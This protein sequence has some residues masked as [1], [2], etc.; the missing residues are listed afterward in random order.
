MSAFALTAA[1]T[2]LA[3]RWV[4]R[5]NRDMGHQP[6]SSWTVLAPAPLA[7]VSPGPRPTLSVVI[8]YYRGADVIRHAVQSV[9]DQTLQ[10]DEIVICDDGS[11]DDLETALG[12]LRSAVR[13]VRKENAGTPSAMNA[14]AR[15]AEGE[16]LVQLDQDDVFLP[17]RLEAIAAAAVSRP[18]LDLIATDAFIEFDGKPICRFSESISF[19]TEDQRTGILRN[20]FFAWPAVRRS[21]LLAAGG[22]DERRTTG[23]YDWE[24][25]MRL[26]LSGARVG[27]VD[28]PL[29]VWKL[30]R[31]SVSSDPTVNLEALLEALID[32]RSHPG[33]LPVERDELER[34]IAEQVGWIARSKARR[35][36]EE[37][38]PDARRRSLALL[39]GRNFGASTRAKAAL[40]VLSPALARSLGMR[41][42]ERDPAARALGSRLMSGPS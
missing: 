33:L 27:L 11:P 40:G 12:T 24:C 15:T 1:H 42:T 38:L 28:E 22:Y 29:Y 37:N 3:E 25:F 19:Q 41:R 32:L 6:E 20:S 21:T 8:P 39:F 4:S 26:I 17:R 2:A 36:I 30:Q 5:D 9:V 16:L 31:G 14:A 18:D 23:Y 35:A 7:S 34:V 10:P 13:I